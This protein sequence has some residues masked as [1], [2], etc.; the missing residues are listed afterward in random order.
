[1]K[2]AI[3][4]LLILAA[5]G[6]LL[7]AC[8]LAPT[9]APPN[10]DQIATY[11]YETNQALQAAAPSSTPEPAPTEAPPTE[12]AA[13]PTTEPTA[14]PPSGPTQ[15]VP[16]AGPTSTPLPD[17]GRVIF[18]S[19]TT[20]ATILDQIE[21]DSANEYLVNIQKGQMLSIFIESDGKVPAIALKDED[22]KELLA[23]SKGFTWYITTV[24]KTQDFTI[25]VVSGDFNSDY[26]L[27]IST[28]TDVVFDSGTTSK[29]YEGVLLA[30]DLIEYKAYA[31]DG[32]DAKITL[33]S[34]SGAARLF[35][36][37]LEDQVTYV[38]LG[39]NAATWE[40]TLPESQTYLIK[41]IA[42][43][44]DTLYTLTVEFTN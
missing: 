36:Y 35:I 19:G 12:A 2:S 32:Q 9:D 31:L 25:E 21:P 42:N 15:A 17:D 41:V 26:V 6:L 24:Q 33:T 38:S 11:V 44:A 34:T 29:S 4:N 5:A 37:G 13:E 20:F 28:P 8:S 16:T 22:G 7:A 43:G 1:M 14:E 39:D 18:D 3:T 10:D 40:A 30:D 23:A 27:H